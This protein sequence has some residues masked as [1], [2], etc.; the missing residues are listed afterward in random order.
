[1][2]HIPFYELQIHLLDK[3][4]VLKLG[5]INLS[6]QECV[7]PPIGNFGQHGISVSVLG[8]KVILNQ[9]E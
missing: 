6:D 9:E 7:V 8:V 1:M 4:S 5:T 2:T 3:C